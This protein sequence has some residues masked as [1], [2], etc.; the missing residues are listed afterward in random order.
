LLHKIPGY[1]LVSLIAA[2][3][4]EKTYIYTHPFFLTDPCYA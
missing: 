2:L 3:L 1:L 4:K